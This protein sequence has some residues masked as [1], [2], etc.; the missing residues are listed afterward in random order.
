MNKYRLT[1]DIE[2]PDDIS[3]DDE[4]EFEDWLDHFTGCVESDIYSYHP[5]KCDIDV[6][7][8]YEAI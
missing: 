7:S 5:L 2:L 1:F 8:N 4:Q 3:Q 6:Y